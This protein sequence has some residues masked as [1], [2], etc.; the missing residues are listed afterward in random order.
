MYVRKAEQILFGI[1]GEMHHLRGLTAVAKII[2][3]SLKKHVV[4]VCRTFQWVENGPKGSYMHT[5]MKRK[6]FFNNCATNI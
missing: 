3:V 6:G 5:I 2:K 4:M 1:R